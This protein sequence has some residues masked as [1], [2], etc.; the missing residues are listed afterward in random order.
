MKVLRI[1]IIIHILLSYVLDGLT[2]ADRRLLNF[3]CTFILH[4]YE[5]LFSCVLFLADIFTRCMHGS[6]SNKISRFMIEN[7][8]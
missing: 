3:S 1:P 6:Y 5:A 7:T 4:S 8:V 2:L